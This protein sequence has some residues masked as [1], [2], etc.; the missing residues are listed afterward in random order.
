MNPVQYHPGKFPPENRLDW[1]RLLPLIGPATSALARYDGM[2][3]AVP[4]P[5]MLLAPLSTQEAVLSSRI[6]GTQATMSEVLGFEAGDR[7]ASP[8]RTSDIHEVINYHRAMAKAEEMLA[9]LPLSGR[10]IRAVHGIL[11]SGARGANRAPG[12]YRRT[13]NWIGP[14]GCTIEE[15]KYVPVSSERLADAM[16][17]WERYIHQED[18]PDLLVQ[19]ANLHAE[20]EALHPFLD[21]NGRLGRMLIPLFL[22]QRG[23]IA[24][25]IFYISAYFEA[26]RDAYYERLL[27]V[28]RDNDWTGWG[29]FFLKAVKHQADDNLAKTQGILNLYDDLKPRIDSATKS[30]HTLRTLDWI[31]QKPVFSSTSFA[32]GTS[33]P[34]PSAHRI[35][36]DLQAHGILQ[37]FS[38]ASG[39]RPALFRFPELLKIVEE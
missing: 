15:A 9:S 11:L 6:E 36:T 22:W 5:N 37:K 31:F 21:G 33:I 29:I 30:R 20:F 3:A 14:P 10:V 8:E 24:R 1:Q 13:P 28:S 7:A 4:N 26:N 32:R 17:R 34:A 39:N 27:A 12:E 25:P 35:L 19:A 38:T 23:R 18:M 16:S 2:L